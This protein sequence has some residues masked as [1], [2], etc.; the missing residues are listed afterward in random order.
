MTVIKLILTNCLVSICLHS[1]AQEVVFINVVGENKAFV[2]ETEI[3]VTLQSDRKHSITL[4]TRTTKIDLS[5]FYF[6]S[7]VTVTIDGKLIHEYVNQYTREQFLKL[8]TISLYQSQR[9]YEP[10]PRVYLNRNYPLDSAIRYE[11]AV[12]KEFFYGSSMDSTFFIEIYHARPLSKKVRKQIEQVKSAFCK[13]AGADGK[14]IQLIDKKTPYA[15]TRMDFFTPTT[16]I[17]EQFIQQQNTP[18][19]KAKAKE[20]SLV[21]V[22]EIVWS[23]MLE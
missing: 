18:W 15:S 14:T 21:L 1:F 7:L 20:Y 22:V 10:T 13:E 16:V 23:K 2:K 4:S 12:L 8:D 11:A 19:M 17:T 9:I 6:D 3:F 5:S